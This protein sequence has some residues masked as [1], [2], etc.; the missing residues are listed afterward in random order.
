MHNEYRFN[1]AYKHI[2]INDPVNFVCNVFQSIRAHNWFQLIDC[3][4]SSV[5]HHIL[6]PKLRSVVYVQLFNQL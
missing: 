4:G 1:K 5:R 2:F 3:K 6:R